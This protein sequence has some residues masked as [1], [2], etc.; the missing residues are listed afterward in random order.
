MIM[1]KLIM[2]NDKIACVVVVM[3]CDR[4]Q[5]GAGLKLGEGFGRDIRK[6]GET[7]PDFRLEVQM[8]SKAKLETNQIKESIS[9][10]I[11]S[12]Y[13][14]VDYGLTYKTKSETNQIK[15]SLSRLV[16]SSNI[17]VGY[18]IDR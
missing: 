13:I 6:T 2:I 10:Q 12:N 18:G 15:E 7:L 5:F 9:R 3:D 4:N 14:L 1:L 8:L 16:K 17:P 11:K